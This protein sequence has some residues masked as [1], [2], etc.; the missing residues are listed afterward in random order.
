MDRAVREQVAQAVVVAQVAL[1]AQVAVVVLQVRA[2]GRAQQ[3]E[4]DPVPQLEKA[5]GRRAG[6][7]SR[8]AASPYAATLTAPIKPTDKS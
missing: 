3:L 4:L 1:V 7:A 2:A 5:S 8:A 6:L